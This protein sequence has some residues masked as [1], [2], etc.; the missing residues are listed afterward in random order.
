MKNLIFFIMI[1]LVSCSKHQDD[2]PKE[3]KGYSLTFEMENE[4]E[5][6]YHIQL[7]EDSIHF[8]TIDT[9]HRDPMKNGVYTVDLNVKAGEFVRVATVG[10]GD[11]VFSQVIRVY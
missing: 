7:S 4:E 2:V 6:V 1:L 10:A 3:D 9:L 8:T 5:S 11:T